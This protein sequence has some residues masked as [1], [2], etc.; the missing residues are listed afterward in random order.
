[1][2]S[3]WCRYKSRIV[4][5]FNN[6]LPF[7]HFIMSIS[8]SYVAGGVHHKLYITLVGTVKMKILKNKVCTRNFVA[9]LSSAHTVLPVYLVKY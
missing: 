7:S 6:K 5:V 3:V 2:H 9:N 8:L 4:I 1:M